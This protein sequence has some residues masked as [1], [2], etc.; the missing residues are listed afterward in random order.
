MTR[1][2]RLTLTVGLLSVSCLAGM[3]HADSSK[4]GLLK[5]LELQTLNRTA[6]HA[7]PTKKQPS[8]DGTREDSGAERERSQPPQDDRG[9]NDTARTRQP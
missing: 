6:P 1:I 3:A 8:P 5:L 2:V 4:Q 9:A 7:A